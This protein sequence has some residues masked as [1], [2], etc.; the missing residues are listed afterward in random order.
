MSF[1]KVEFT[2]SD[3]EKAKEMVNQLRDE[4]LINGAGIFEYNSIYKWKENEVDKKS[5]LISMHVQ[6][7][8]L[9]K[10]YNK[11]ELIHP[12]EIPS[13]ECYKINKLNKD[14]KKFLIDSL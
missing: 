8:L 11:I 6:Q 3:Y 10:V 12:Y 13:I 9:K 4:K 1:Y 14:Y 2:F 5:Y 7:K